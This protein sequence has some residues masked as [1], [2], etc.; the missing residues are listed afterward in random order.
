[1]GKTTLWRAGVEAAEAAGC[2]SCR[3]N[4]PRARRPS[5]SPGSATSSTRCSTRRSSRCRPDSDRRSRAR[6][7]SRRSRGRRP[8][9]T[10]SASRCS[11]RSGGSRA[12]AT[13]S[14]RSTTSQWLDAASSAALAYGVATTQ[15]RARRCPARAPLG[16]RELA[17]GRAEAHAGGERLQRPRRRPA[18]SRRRC[19]RSCRATSV[20][21]S[22]DRCWRRCARRREETRSTRSRSCARSLARAC[23]SRPDSRCR[24]PTPSTTSSTVAC[25]RCRPRA[26]TSCSRPQRTRTRPSR[27]RRRRPVSGVPSGLVAG[28]RG[29]H[30]RDRGRPDPLH[31][32]AARRGRLRDGRSAASSREIHARLAELLEDPEARAWQL[33]ASVDEPGREVA[34]CS[35]KRRDTR[36]TRGALRPGRA[37]PRARRAAHAAI[38]RTTQCRRAVEAAYLHFES[39]DSR[40]AE[41]KLREVIA[42][43]PPGPQR[44]RALVRARADPLYEAPDEARS[45]SLQVVEEAGRRSRDAR[46]SRTRASPRAASGC[47]SDSMRRSSTRTSHSLSHARSATTHSLRTR[48]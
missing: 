25:S 32:S 31:A 22:L 36:V 16:P 47:S 35:R 33:A 37:S 15:R 28:A 8:M 46:A 3:R 4:P 43:L 10:R 21:R 26:G 45:S 38:D 19:T 17:A 29:A 1:M 7:S 20:S 5:A 24:C 48:S 27:S 2:A 34:R 23:P 6:S 18:R 11:T 14:S 30:R 9:R 40:R 42:P 41:A 12:A 44:A 39:G 13:S